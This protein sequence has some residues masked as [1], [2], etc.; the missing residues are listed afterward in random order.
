MTGVEIGVV[1]VAGGVDTGDTFGDD[2]FEGLVL[3]TTAVVPLLT[4]LR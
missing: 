2:A 1:A 4:K 3:P